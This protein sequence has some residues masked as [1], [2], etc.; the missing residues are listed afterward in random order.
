M[1]EGRY[2]SIFQSRMSAAD[3]FRAARDE[4]RLWL[5]DKAYDMEAFDRGDPRVGAG[6]ILLHNAANSADGTQTERWRLRESRDGGAWVSELTV[7]A[8]ADAT[9]SGPTWFWAEVEFV[10]QNASQDPAQGVQAAVPRLARGLL[11]TVS[12]R[13]SLAMLTNEPSVVT[14]ERVDELIDVLCDP[15]RRL[16]A[17][18]ASAHPAIGF[19]VWKDTIG[20]IT[21]RLPGLASIYLLDPLATAEFDRNIGHAYAVWGGALRTYMPEVDPAVDDDAARHRVLTAARVLADPG[22]AAGILSMLPRRLAVEA[23]LPAALAGST[24]DCS[25]K[26][27]PRRKPT[28]FMASGHSSRSSPRNGTSRSVSPRI[29]RDGP[30]PSSVREKASWQS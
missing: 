17:V 22:R 3:G 19:A 11:E 24:A 13:D 8:P 29:K 25:R 21:R 28:I 26:L 14:R 2:R 4:M 7:H 16:P 5:R 18:V 27:A 12:A 15:E 30:T 23:P 6:A 9:S 1:T 10:P 20:R